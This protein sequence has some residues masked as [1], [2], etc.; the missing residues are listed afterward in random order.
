MTGEI[1]FQPPG[2]LT[3]CKHDA[4]LAKLTFK[5]NIRAET[6]DNPFVGAARMGL[7]QTQVI[8]KL[9]VR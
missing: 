7:A 3:P 8:V 6:D 5:T 9:Q 4:V 1:D 2:K